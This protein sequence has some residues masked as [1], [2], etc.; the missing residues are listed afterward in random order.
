MLGT[1]IVPFPPVW[2]NNQVSDNQNY[3]YPLWVNDYIMA[4]K[5]KQ[6]KE[7]SSL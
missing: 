3:Y 4:G 1:I 7:I 2:L 5:L 6:M